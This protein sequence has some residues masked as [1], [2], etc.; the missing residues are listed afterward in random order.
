MRSVVD[1]NVV[2]RRIPAPTRATKA[3]RHDAERRFSQG[4]FSFQNIV[5]TVHADVLISFTPISKK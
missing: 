4:V 3:T 2:M 1:R 5:F